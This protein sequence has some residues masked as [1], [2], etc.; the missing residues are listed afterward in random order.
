MLAFFCPWIRPRAALRWS[1]QREWRDPTAF[2]FF[3]QTQ[4]RNPSLLHCLPTKKCVITTL[5]SKQSL[6]SHL[7]SWVAVRPSN[8][9]MFL[10]TTTN[11]QQQFCRL[12]AY[13]TRTAKPPWLV[14]VLV[15]HHFSQWIPVFFPKYFLLAINFTLFGWWS[16]PVILFSCS[17]PELRQQNP[18]V[19]QLCNVRII[20]QNNTK[21]NKNHNWIQWEW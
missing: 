21:Q 17:L 12:L 2:F 7:W 6:C 10:P 1:D 14:K 8:R 9:W 13:H 5:L 4:V 19:L 18:L 16:I 20:I 11:Y 15:M 3:Q